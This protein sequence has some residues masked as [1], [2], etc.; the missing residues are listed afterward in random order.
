MVL[1][2]LKTYRVSCRVTSRLVLESGWIL[3]RLGGITRSSPLVLRVTCQAQSLAGTSGYKSY[4]I[5]GICS[6]VT[7]PLRAYD[8]VTVRS[9][10]SINYVCEIA[11]G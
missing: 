6:G 4:R 2:C 8:L 5:A 1:V 10:R 11:F 3:R 9:P 7:V